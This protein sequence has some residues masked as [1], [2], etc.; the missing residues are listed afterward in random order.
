MSFQ[1]YQPLMAF[2]LT[3]ESDSLLG[4]SFA[5]QGMKER[6]EGV[7]AKAENQLRCAR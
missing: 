7:E 4:Q 3:D 2:A 6:T 5:Q 1:C